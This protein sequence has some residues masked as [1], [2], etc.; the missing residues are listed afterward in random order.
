MKHSTQADPGGSSMTRYWIKIIVGALLIFAVGM[1]VWTMGKKGV[2]TAHAVFESSDPIS[3]PVK[4][5]DFRVDGSPLG[6]I[7]KITLLRS[8]PDKVT[9][10]EVTVRLDSAAMADRIRACAMRVEDIENFD[11][12][13][14]FVCATED[15]PAGAESFE[16]FGQVLVEG[17]DITMPLMLPAAAV[18]DFQRRG[19]DAPPTPVVPPAPAVPP[20]GGPQ[21]TGAAATAPAP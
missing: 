4:I 13:K 14:S 7:R 5:V 3:I 10:V 1:T 12:H 11:E 2:N 6:K 17:T 19:A 18:R 16:P 21:G 15:M 8:A 20:T 9:S